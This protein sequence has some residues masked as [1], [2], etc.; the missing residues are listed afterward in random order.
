MQTPDSSLSCRTEK[1]KSSPSPY[2]QVHSQ[3]LVVYKTDQVVY[4]TCRMHVYKFPFDTQSCN[5]S[6]RSILLSDR[7]I[8]LRSHSGSLMTRWSQQVMRTQYEWVLLNITVSKSTGALFNYPQETITYTITM[9]RRSVLYIVNF[10]LPVVFFLILDLASFL[11]SDTGGE[12]LGFKITILLAVT[13]MQLLLNDILPSSSNRI[14]LIAVFCIGVFSLMLLS[15]LESILVLFLI[16]KDQK[17]EQDL[18]RTITQLHARCEELRT[19][20]KKRLCFTLRMLLIL[21]L[22]LLS[23]AVLCHENCTYQELLEHLGLTSNDKKDLLTLS[24]PVKNTSSALKVDLHFR[25]R[26]ILGVREIEQT[27]ISDTSIELSWENEHLKWNLSSFCNKDRIT[28]PSELLWKPDLRILEMVEKDKTPPSPFLVLKSTGHV[29]MNQDQVI[30][31]SCRMHVYK[32]PFDMQSCNLSIK[33]FVHSS[34]EL[35]L[36]NTAS[37]DLM[38]DSIRS[39]MQ[40]EYEWLFEDIKF[41]NTSSNGMNEPQSVLVYMVTV[42][43]RSALYVVNFILPILFFL[44]LDFASF[45]M[46]D[47]GGDKLGFKI[48]I[49]LAVTVLQLLLN[50]ILPSSS[51]RIPLIA[52]FCLGVFWLMKLSLLETIVVMYLLEQDKKSQRNQ[53]TEDTHVLKKNRCVSC[54]CEEHAEEQEHTEETQ[55][56]TL[57]PA[58]GASGEQ[59]LLFELHHVCSVLAQAAGGNSEQDEGYW[60]SRVPR[61]HK[62]FLCVYSTCTCVFLGVIFYRWVN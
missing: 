20:L 9:K 19:L 53:Q 50:D 41:E 16:R 32:F 38:K 62:V 2:L 5:L 6:F 42:R 17:R 44:F 25:P 31:S 15:L 59:R 47:T 49:L 35:V 26:A 60:S 39:Q 3:G 4:S 1:D 11:M 40:N 30:V 27:F 36:E 22:L 21:Q 18:K 24:P 14:P 46:S 51:N 43:R 23:G 48:T 13:V 34:S 45:L 61:I 29:M 58:G 54:L 33:S 57:S 56:H 10:L 12:K 8:Q 28:V 37:E 55:D 7:E 52:I